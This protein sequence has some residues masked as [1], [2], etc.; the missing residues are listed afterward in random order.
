[1]TFRLLDSAVPNLFWAVLAFVFGSVVGSFLNVCIY[2][3]P[4]EESVVWPGSRCPSCKKPIA[5]FDNIP[6]I[7]WLSLRARCR[8]CK[9]PIAWRY[10]LVEALSGAATLIVLGKFGFN[11]HGLIYLFFVYALIVVTFIDLDFQIIPDEISVGGTIVGMLLSVLWPQLHGVDSPLQGWQA[12][13]LGVLVGGGSLYLTGMLGDFLF[14]KESMGG[15]DIKLLAMAGSILGWQAVAIAFFLSPML[16]LIPGLLLIYFKKEHVIPYG[17]F[18]AMALLVALFADDWLL[19][20]T[21]VD[22]TIRLIREYH[23]WH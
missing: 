19:R 9:K 8:H 7:S 11:P 3:M 17:P 20:T 22:E 16:A 10:P 2:R 15:G 6:I 12:A 1:M 5:W 23:Q 21:G 4:R 18:L 14:K 13:S